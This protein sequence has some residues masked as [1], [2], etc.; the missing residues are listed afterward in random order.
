MA[1]LISNWTAV[2]D[3][4]AAHPDG[5]FTDVHGSTL[6]VMAKAGMCY[7]ASDGKYYLLGRGPG[8]GEET[9][10]TEHTTAEEAATDLASRKAAARLFEHTRNVTCWLDNENGRSDDE[11]TLR[12]RKVGEEF[13]E[14]AQASIGVLAQNPRKGRSH[15]PADVSNAL[16]DV[17]L[18]ALIALESVTDDAECWFAGYLDDRYEGMLSMIA[19]QDVKRTSESA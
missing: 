10:E 19:K 14:V 11:V 5:M 8:V 18:A 4:A 12:V 2:S 3:Q 17:A 1:D 6:K 9:A 15:T 13:G 16:C 7:K